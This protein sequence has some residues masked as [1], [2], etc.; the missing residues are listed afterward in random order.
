[1]NY[2]LVKAEKELF[3][4]LEK[5]PDL[6]PMQNALSSAMNMHG[7]DME[8]RFLAFSVFLQYNLSDLKFELLQ[9]KKLLDKN[10]N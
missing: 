6:V 1:M 8:K 7:Y 10:G 3:E 5:N 4:F 2:E 9:L